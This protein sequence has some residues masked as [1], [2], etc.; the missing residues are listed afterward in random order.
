MSFAITP[1][2]AVLIL[3]VNDPTNN[4]A[5]WT[6]SGSEITITNLSNFDA[7]ITAFGFDLGN[8]DLTSAVLTVSGTLNNGDWEL[9]FN[10][11]VGGGGGGTFDYGVTTA[12][13]GNLLG[14]QT[15]SGITTIALPLTNTGI[16]DFGVDLG[17]VTD[18]YVRFQRTGSDENGSDRGRICRDIDC[19]PPQRVP[20]PSIIALFGLGLLGL[21][22]ARRRMRS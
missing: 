9:V 17:E 2:W 8:P 18:E 13:S 12:N 22:L 20:E 14:G 7:R 10:Q 4:R 1:A 3:G 19:E 15:N 6:V 16:F 5:D 11:T 21:G